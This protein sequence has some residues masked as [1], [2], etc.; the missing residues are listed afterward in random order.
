M[1]ALMVSHHAKIPPC[2][3]RA[4]LAIKYMPVAELE[5]PRRQTRTHTKKQLTQIGASMLRFEVLSPL[6]VAGRVVVCGEGRRLAAIK[7][8]I[9]TVPTVDVSHLTE[10]ERRLYA[11][12]ENRL[13][14]EAGWDP[15][16]LAL[17]IQE[18]DDLD[19]GIEL[20][21]TGFEGAELEDLRDGGGPKS[22]PKADMVPPVEALAV[23]RPGDV[24]LLGERHRLIC[25]D[26]RNPEAYATLMQGELARMVLSDPPFNV[27]IVGNVGGKGKAARR[28]FLMCSGEMS[29]PVFTTFLADSLGRMF[30]T[31]CDGAIAFI[32]MDWRHIAEMIVAGHA[33]F[34]A[35]K[36]IIVWV[37]TNGGMGSFYRSQHEFI[38]VLK[39]GEAPHVNTFGLG[40]T[41][42]FRTN[43]WNYP[44]VNTFRA[45][46]DEELAWHPTVKPVALLADAIRDVSRRG[47]IVLDAFAGSGSVAIAAEKTKRRA[48][49]IE[50]DPLYCDVICRRW[51]KFAK[52]PA[53]LAETGQTFDDVARQRGAADE[54]A[55]DV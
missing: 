41:G 42:R 35:P 46:R 54:G 52:A 14:E 16:L 47:E 44:G 12:A 20:E 3:R 38:F 31:C 13:A 15:E 22:D 39:K 4:D 7:V 9:E 29:R 1:E 34:G 23:T 24:W 5:P 19:L 11:L 40:E 27:K 30:E 37:K 2:A 36:N 8:G 18:L 33:T 51:A 49:L 53:V 26:A 17:E 6:L 50:L 48:R 25:S 21:I 32:F 10:A 43:V 55:C 45:G 28:E